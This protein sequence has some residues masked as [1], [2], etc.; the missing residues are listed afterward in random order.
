MIK[1]TIFVVV[2]VVFTLISDII[3]CWLSHKCA[4][5][6]SIAFVKASIDCFYGFLHIQLYLARSEACFLFL[7]RPKDPVAPQPAAVQQIVAQSPL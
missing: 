3:I 5:A 2:V 7:P 1:K 4:S 6:F